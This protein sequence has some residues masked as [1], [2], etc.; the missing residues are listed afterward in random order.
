MEKYV[1]VKI[2]DANTHEEIFSFH[3]TPNKLK[4]QL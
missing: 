4:K 1:H 3:R 2:N